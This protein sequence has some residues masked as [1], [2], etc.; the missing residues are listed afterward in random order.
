V[1][2]EERY[3]QTGWPDTSLEFLTSA[4]KDLA[5]FRQIVTFGAAEAGLAVPRATPVVSTPRVS[6]RLDVSSRVERNLLTRLRKRF[7]DPPSDVRSVDLP[8]VE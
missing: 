6:S 1:A 5:F 3:S 8:G 7:I 2:P 4:Q